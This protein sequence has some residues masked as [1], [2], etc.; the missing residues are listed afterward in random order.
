MPEKRTELMP[1]MALVVGIICL[2]FSAIFVKAANAPGVVSG[3]YRMAIAAIVFAVPFARRRKGNAPL[4]KKGIG[5]AL[6]GG[7]FFGLD[8]S[9]WTEGIMISGPT[10]PTL[11]AN[12]APAWVGVG[13]L[14]IFKEKLN[15]KFW[16]GLALAMAG[17]ALILGMDSLKAFSLG[18]GTAFGL[19]A[20]V[21]YGA[22][23]LTAQRGRNT[24]DVISF[25]W[26]SVV[27]STMVLFLIGLVRGVS[28]TDYPLESWMYFL[29]AGLIS[30]V[31]G[32][33]AI[34]YAQG[35]LP[36]TVVSPTLLGQPIMTAILAIF[37]LGDVL[38]LWQIVGGTAIISGIY[39]V[40]RARAAARPRKAR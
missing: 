13:A 29:A 21:F 10:N 20:G 23:F 28:F 1:Y 32:W 31:V 4:P 38:S 5:L 35:Y 2:G 18:M 25:F 7:L 15:G 24:M 12:T 40:H 19:I 9:F 8:M 17:A 39:L 37:M 14:L 36:A 34:T 26:F 16:F 11:M 6:L 33:F 27:G 22:F 3:F 30:Q